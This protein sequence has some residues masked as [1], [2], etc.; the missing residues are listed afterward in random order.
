MTVN[1]NSR[2]GGR[3]LTASSRASLGVPQVIISPFRPLREDYE[4]IF[5]LN[6]II[7]RIKFCFPYIFL[8]VVSGR[9]GV[10]VLSIPFRFMVNLTILILGRG[11]LILSSQQERN[12]DRK[13]EQQTGWAEPAAS[14]WHS[15]TLLR[16]VITP[17]R[18]MRLSSGLCY[19]LAKRIRRSHASVAL[20][21]GLPFRRCHRLLPAIKDQRQV[22]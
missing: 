19:S 6:P 10:V 17:I 4:A 9:K 1:T 16:G 15:S 22:D 18:P 20:L 11:P 2:L 3:N 13:H 21:R 14:A 12:G 5:Q 7:N 8:H